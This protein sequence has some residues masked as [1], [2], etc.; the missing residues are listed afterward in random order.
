MSAA[1]RADAPISPRIP[2]FPLGT[3]LFPGGRLPLRVFEARY[4]DMVRNC[5]RDGSAFGICRITQGQEVGKA[6]EHEAIGCLARIIDWDMAQAGVLQIRVVGDRR[7]RVLERQVETD[8]L[9]TATIDYL[10]DDPIVPVPQALSDCAGL[11]RRIIEDLERRQA[12]AE[13]RPVVP[14]YQ[15]DSCAWVGNRLCELLPLSTAARQKLMELDDP[16]VRLS[17][18]RQFL[19]QRKVL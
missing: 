12:D 13:Q 18:V 4:M 6:A 15:F 11:L 3:V 17:L 7:F 2:I 1:V 16:G 14:P 9:V 10:E 8:G 19:E 5:M